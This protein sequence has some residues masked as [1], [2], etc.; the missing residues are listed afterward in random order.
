[1]NRSRS[2]FLGLVLEGPHERTD[3][4]TF[5]ISANSQKSFRAGLDEVVNVS[6]LDIGQI[7]TNIS[8]KFWQLNE[9][10][11]ILYLWSLWYLLELET[12][13]EIWLSIFVKINFSPMT[14]WKRWLVTHI[15][16]HSP[17]R[18]IL[19]ILSVKELDFISE[20]HF[21]ETF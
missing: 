21:S 7:F 8:W 10:E 5:S 4:K 17:P 15:F 1:M 20:K 12:E 2:R 9:W 3:L 6:D 14:I 18:V 19:P 11:P 16:G 13:S